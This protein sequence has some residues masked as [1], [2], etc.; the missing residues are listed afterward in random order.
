MSSTYSFLV[1][2]AKCCVIKT[3]YLMLHG[4]NTEMYKKMKGIQNTNGFII[5]KS[6]KVWHLSK[7][8]IYTYAMQWHFNLISHYVFKFKSYTR[9][10]ARIKIK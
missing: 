1:T 8:A 10:F 5:A 2:A 7:H 6:G 9:C 3:A 4:H